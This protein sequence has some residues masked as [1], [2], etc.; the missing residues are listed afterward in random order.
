M[1]FLCASIKS[2]LQL[3]LLFCAKSCPTLCEPM[4]CSLSGS[5]VHGIFQARIL[6]WDPIP[7]D[8]LD[9]GIKPAS[10]ACFSC[11]GRWFYHQT[12]RNPEHYHSSEFLYKE[13]RVRH[14]W[15]TEVTNQPSVILWILLFFLSIANIMT[16]YTYVL[17]SW[18]QKWSQFF[19]QA[20]I[21]AFCKVT[22]QL[23]SVR[24]KAHFLTVYIWTVL[25]FILH[26][27]WLSA[28]F[29]CLAW[30]CSLTWVPPF[31]VRRN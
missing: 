17:L 26:L 23:L 18:L 31:L 2:L 6:E 10:P 4:H 22:L 20:R 29:K 14:D 7:E 13:Q 28:T 24:G 8:L 5:S 3:L 11:I 15:A 30:F 21:H 27:K 9:P 16:L 19:T 12:P 1:V 25:W